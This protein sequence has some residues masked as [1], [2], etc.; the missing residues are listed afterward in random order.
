MVSDCRELWLLLPTSSYGELQRARNLSK[1]LPD[2]DVFSGSEGGRSKAFDN[3]AVVGNSGTLLE[4]EFGNDIDS[5]DVVFRFNQ[6]ITEGYE[7]HVGK[8]TTFRILNKH[9]SGAAV[10]V[11]E[12]TISTIRE[13]GQL[14]AWVRS[15]LEHPRRAAL[16][17]DPEFLCYCWSWV[18]RRGHK[19]SSG[20]VGIVLALKSCHS[21]TIFGFSSSSYYN[22]E[23][24][25]HY[26]DWERPAKG[27]ERVHP[28]QYEQKLYHHLHD[29]GYLSIRS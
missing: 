24:R 1:V 14:R 8:K 12:K 3:C 19:P 26:Y 17:F 22:S 27:R 13:M 11:G 20:L 10:E 21:T 7:P 16:V 5:H 18:G 4:S 29:L 25:P 9:Q 28:F 6:G 23:E 15:T 2:V